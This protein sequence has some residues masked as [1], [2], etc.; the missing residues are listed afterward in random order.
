MENVELD[1]GKNRKTRLCNRKERKK[2]GGGKNGG[3]Q[4]KGS[5]GGRD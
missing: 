2:E 3:E 1:K 4:K 5:L